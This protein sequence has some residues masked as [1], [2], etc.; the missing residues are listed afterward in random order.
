MSYRLHALEGSEGFHKLPRCRSR[1]SHAVPVSTPPSHL[2]SSVATAP[3]PFAP[4]VAPP[5]FCRHS[6]SVLLGSPNRDDTTEAGSGW[7]R[8]AG[9]Q[10]LG[11]TLD[12]SGLLQ[13]LWQRPV[14]VCGGRS[15][16]LPSPVSAQAAS[17]RL[18]HAT[19]DALTPTFPSLL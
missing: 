5:L 7:R 10:A 3:P 6:T 12:R 18:L 16:E 4:T 19:H 11:T 9:E 2:P 17:P 8:P 15:M 13:G 14:S 1:L